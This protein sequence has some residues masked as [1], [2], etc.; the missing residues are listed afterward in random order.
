MEGIMVAAEAFDSI[1][2]FVGASVGLLVAVSLALFGYLAERR[3]RRR[4][5]SGWPGRTVFRW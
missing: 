1:I 4:K 3:R 5:L 2:G